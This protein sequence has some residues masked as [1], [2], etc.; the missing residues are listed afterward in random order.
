MLATAIQRMVCL[1]HAL[2]FVS[3]GLRSCCN[4]NRTGAYAARIQAPAGISWKVSQAK[5]ALEPR[6][7]RPPPGCSPLPPP[8]RRRAPRGLGRWRGWAATRRMGCSRFVKDEM[9]PQILAISVRSLQGAA[10]DQ[11][12]RHRAVCAILAALTTATPHTGSDTPCAHSSGICRR[13]SPAQRPSS[14]RQPAWPWVW[15]S[16]KPSTR[17][18]TPA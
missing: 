5:G 9:S 10:H 8:A 7:A 14:D 4:A 15:A 2:P 3:S 17:C 16:T 12:V 1:G 13:D 11:W 18:S 6:S